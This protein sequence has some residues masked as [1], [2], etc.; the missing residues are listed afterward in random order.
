M[1]SRHPLDPSS[2]TR[3]DLCPCSYP[4][5]R[6]PNSS[7]RTAFLPREPKA[8]F[9]PEIFTTQLWSIILAPAHYPGPWASTHGPWTSGWVPGEAVAVLLCFSFCLTHPWRLGLNAS[10]FWKPLEIFPQRMPKGLCVAPY[11]EPNDCRIRCGRHLNDSSAS[12]LPLLCF[13]PGELRM[14]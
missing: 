9:K 12:S 11:P 7:P 14:E 13:L 3:R 10:P 6:A 8:S 1:E 2:Q 4:A 5:L